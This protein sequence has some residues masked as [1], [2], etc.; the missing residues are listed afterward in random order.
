MPT[1]SPVALSPI[2]LD[3]QVNGTTAGSQSE[4][5]ITALS[6]GGFVVTWTDQSGVGDTSGRGVRGQIFDA[7]GST[8]GPEFQINATTLN[9]HIN[10]AV[11]ALTGGGFVVTWSDSSTPSADREIRGR[12]FD[13]QGVP[14]TSGPNGGQ[15][16]IVN[17]PSLYGKL[18]PGI[19]ALADG[20]F[21]VTWQDNNNSGDRNAS[22]IRARFFNAD[23]SSDQTDFVVNS[24]A[25]GEQV[26]PT[27]TALSNG[28]LVVAWQ[29]QLSDGSGTSLRARIFDPNVIFVD[30]DF[31]VNST[32]QGGQEA[33]TLTALAD[34][35]FIVTWTDQSLA[36]DTSGYGIRARR[37]D[38]DGQ[39]I[40]LD[41]QVNSIRAGNQ[42]YPKVTARPD[43]GYV[44]SWYDYN[45][46]GSGS[47]IR[48]QAYNSAGIA[49]GGEFLVNSTLAGN[50][51]GPTMTTLSNGTFVIAWQG[52][53]A[54][55]SGTGIRARIFVTDNLVLGDGRDDVL[56][57]GTG[58][59]TLDGG[60]GNDTLTGG[61][62]DNLLLG[63][64]GNDSLS[65]QA[66]GN[67]TVCGGAG[68][69]TLW[70]GSGN[71]SLTGD[72]GNDRITG[73][74]GQDTLSGGAGNDTLDGGDD[75][76]VAIFSGARSDYLITHFTDPGT[77]D[78]GFT[79][80]DT[81]SGSPDGQDRLYKIETLTFRDGSIETSSLG[82]T[83]VN[84]GAGDDSLVGSAGP[85]DLRGLG[86]ND[87][88]CG[89][90]GNDNLDGGTG[91]DIA[92]F[93][94]AW[95]DYRVTLVDGIVTV[96]DIRPGS[97]DGQDILTN[98][99]TLKFRDQSVQTETLTANAQFVNLV[100]AAGG[101]RYVAN[102]GDDTLVGGKGND[103]LSGQGGAD[104]LVGGAGDDQLDGG[105]GRDTAVFS[106]A[107]ADYAIS[108][109]GGSVTVSDLRA[110]SPDG[111]DQLTNIENFQFSDQTAQLVQISISSSEM[112]ATGGSG[113]DTL[114][115]C[116]LDDSLS[117]AAGNDSLTGGDGHDELNG[118]TG[119]DT[120]SG[121]SGD[122]WVLGGKDND[123]VDGGTGND[124][125]YGNLGNDTALGGEGAD[126][127]R[128]GQGDDSVSGGAGDDWLWGDRG[129]DTISGGTGADSFHSFV[130][131]GLDRITDFN[132]REGDRLILDGSPT[133]TVS[134]VGADTLVDLGHGDQVVLVGV[135]YASLSAGWILGG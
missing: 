93:S 29:D 48:A 39:P 61:N 125:V 103:D 89:G 45:T 21:V 15:D 79:V 72:A 12:V 7:S 81:R 59:D 97:P 58:Q 25:S 129:S 1:T 70:A 42:F 76:D 27:L 41:F 75:Y 87:T 90:A 43:G 35:G 80:L 84:G 102:S 60:A 57:A 100:F 105:P 2:G 106:G 18:H 74:N 118:N 14:V 77:G 31:L 113:D 126:T 36:D 3:F 8:I 40:G 6:D 78:E 66:P 16:F 10:S 4:A 38:A 115:G 9:E 52:A 34:G 51:V 107:R 117:G 64:D 82:Q 95:S 132:R 63:Q 22:C 96:R 109:A 19:T 104:S 128:G 131:A 26:N 86:G 47:C 17:S 65:A 33:P 124:I 50:Q 71:N 83:Q 123:L 85:D 127:V 108:V 111:T 30:S 101:M 135:T 49:L 99:E 116:A 67:D 92:V 112:D 24:T 91:N 62:G 133:Y 44:I 54:D 23:G 122:D 68:N 69:D 73:G 120:V 110:G 28:N 121:G 55:G 114:A 13:S 32:T 5:A 130:G 53:Q 88:L 119:N 46:D 98:V 94:G 20:G 11:T 37:F 56:S 134:Q